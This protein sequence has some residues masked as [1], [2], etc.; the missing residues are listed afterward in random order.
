VLTSILYR[1]TAHGIS[2][3]DNTANPGMTFVGNFPPCLQST[4]IPEQSSS[5]ST[6]E[7]M[8]YLPNTGTIGEMITFYYTFVDSAPY[9]PII[10]LTGVDQQLFYDGGVEGKNNQAL[11]K[12]RESMVDFI[13]GYTEGNKIPNLPANEAQIHQWPMGIET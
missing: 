2:R 10:P 7:L 9:E 12:F 3:V 5:F 1:I 11:I 13:K 6:K 8:E 4:H